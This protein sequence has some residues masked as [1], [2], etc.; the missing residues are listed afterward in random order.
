MPLVQT[1]G[2]ASAQGFGEFAQAAPAIPYIEDVFSTYL[3]TG[4]GTGINNTIVNGIDLAG[5]GGMVWTKTRNVAN[6]NLLCTTSLGFSNYL[7]SET[8]D[9]LSAFGSLATLTANNNG[10]TVND[11]NGSWNGTGQLQVSWTFREQPKFFDVVTYTGN[12]TAKTIAHNLESTPGMVIVKRT[13]SSSAWVVGHRGNSAYWISETLRLNTTAGGVTNGEFNSWTSSDV[14]VVNSGA[15]YGDVN[16]NGATYVMYLFAHN[17]GGFGT[18]GTDNVI[19][20]GSYT[21]NGSA[22]GPVVTLGYEPQWLMIKRTSST[23]AWNITDVMRGFSVTGNQFLEA[24]TGGAEYSQFNV[25][26]T[27]TGFQLTS[28]NAEF[29]ASGGTYIYMAIRRPMKVP[30]TGASVFNS[31]A[32]TG[33]GAVSSIAGVGFPTD[34]AIYSTRTAY[35]GNGASWGN[36]L[37]GR[38][39]QL[40][41]Y[42]PNAE[43]TATNQLTGFDSMTSVSIDD[44]TAINASGQTYINWM[45][46]RAS[47]FFDIVCYNPTNISGQTYNHNL[48]AVPEL[49]IIRNRPDGGNWAVYSSAIGNTNYLY[50]NSAQ[51]ITANSSFWNDTTPTSTVFTLGNNA[52]VNG[53]PAIW[54]PYVAFLFATVAGVSKVGSYTGTGATQ[55]INCGFTGGARFVLIKRTNDAGN[56]FVWDTVRGMVSGTDPRLTLNSATAEANNDW[57]LTTSTGFQIVTT[58]ATV[59][60][61]GGSYIFLAIA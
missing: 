10:Y 33:N 53:N 23:G 11:A 60:A 6:A 18:S 44:A 2:A 22:T 34:L 25:R 46:K 37:V 47:G 39:R 51:S 13:D 48:G 59:N 21:G 28:T 8:T 61:S 24:N 42:N 54:G 26:P 27:A 35:L 43:G 17:A 32:R 20:C 45:F 55:T 14:I 19:S 12:G 58:D 56:W 3:Y 41:S 4:T 38:N 7:I 15:G 16:T 40:Y 29:N 31:I 57:V 36:R 49:M 30:T 1:R 9:R 5:K 52:T 50:L